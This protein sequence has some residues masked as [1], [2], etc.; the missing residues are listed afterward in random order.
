MSTSTGTSNRLGRRITARG[1]V[2]ALVTAI[3]LGG[4]TFTTAGASAAPI[5]PLAGGVSIDAGGS[6]ADGTFVPD[7]FS[8]GG[9]LDTKP[10]AKPSLPNFRATVPHPISEDVWHTAR[11]LGSTTTIPGLTPGASYELRLYFLD[12]Y[13]TRP[14]Q[15]VFDVKVQGEPAL[16]DFDIIR[17][18]I[19][20]GADGANSFGVERDL[21]VVADATGTVTVEFLRGKV[22]QPLINAI[23]L[24]PAAA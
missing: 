3:V 21:T 12:W 19:D 20:R 1:G 4:L 9:Y 14:G 5:A 8:T 6:V 13:F 15:R 7:S 18:A 24:V 23:T 10:A 17:T 22:N 11:V 2:T 16:V